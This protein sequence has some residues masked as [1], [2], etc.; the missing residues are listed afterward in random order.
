[1]HSEFV[2][3]PL[4]GIM[5]CYVCRSAAYVDTQQNIQCVLKMFQLIFVPD[6]ND[7][8]QMMIVKVV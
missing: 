8:N 7:T 3:R 6:D 4:Y 1:M 5:L 2:E